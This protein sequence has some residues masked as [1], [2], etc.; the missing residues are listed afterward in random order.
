[1]LRFLTAGESHGQALV[2]VIE[3][4]PAGLRIDFEGIDGDLARRQAGYGRGQRMRIESDH[5]E[6]LSGVRDGETLGSPIAL[7]IRNRDWKNWQRTMHMG[8]NPSP[9]PPVR[10][11]PRSR[12]LGPATPTWPAVLKY[13]RDDLRDVLERASARETAAR[14][15][16]GA[17]ARQVLRACSIEVVSHVRRIGEVA[18]RGGAL[19]HNRPGACAGRRTPKWPAW[20]TR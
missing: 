18:L 17:L 15:A 20:T 7:L 19:G 4:L 13:D 16:A 14:V 3:G 9:T 12:G 6:F 10:C 8:P 1:M 2:V 11:G 5:A